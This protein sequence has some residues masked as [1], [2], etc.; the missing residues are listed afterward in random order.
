[1]ERKEKTG[2]GARSE[3]KVLSLSWRLSKTI[4]RRTR[5]SLLGIRDLF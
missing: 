1:M 3:E 2:G 5:E 4:K